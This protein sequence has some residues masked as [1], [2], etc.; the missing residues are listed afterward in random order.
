MPET[1][2]GSLLASHEQFSPDYVSLR[3]RVKGEVVTLAPSRQCIL[4]DMTA[5]HVPPRPGP[6]RAGPS[7]D[8]R[9]PKS[10]DLGCDGCANAAGHGSV[11]DWA[12]ALAEHRRWLRTVVLSR[13]GDGAAV[14][15]VLQ[16]LALALAQRN[17]KPLEAERV[18]GWLYRVAVRQALLHRRR[19]GRRRRRDDGFAQRTEAA[20]PA[21]PDP[22]QW[23][24]CDEQ[25][26]MVRKALSTLPPPDRELLLL[27]YTE[28]WSCRELARRLGATET[29]V[30]TR[31]H[32]A[33]EKL[34]GALATLEVGP[35]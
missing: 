25:Q 11:I 29:T 28:D 21:E 24:L 34:R 32:R 15:D 26:A 18:T 4:A 13:L 20:R 14:D 12:S 9:P 5:A 16:E 27:K 35:S 10:A 23:L 19:E 7:P 2:Q 17:G 31:L 8:G 6:S 22:L 30:T 33:R 3:D 1:G